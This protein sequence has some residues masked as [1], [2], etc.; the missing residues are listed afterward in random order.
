[1]LRFWVNLVGATSSM[2]L[3]KLNNCRFVKSRIKKSPKQ[4]TQRS[5]ISISFTASA[6]TS[7][8][9]R[10]KRA[11]QF[12]HTIALLELLV[13]LSVDVGLT[14][15]NIIP[16]ALCSLKS[17]TICSWINYFAWPS[18]RIITSYLSL[19]VPL[20]PVLSACL[21]HCTCQSF[22]LDKSLLEYPPW[23]C[24]HLAFSQTQYAPVCQTTYSKCVSF[25]SLSILQG[26]LIMVDAVFLKLC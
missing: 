17:S 9:I 24:Q 21:S 4:T 3:E 14:C 19:C 10:V 8:H 1:M 23:A 22:Q 18:S 2:W 13:S 11:V 12:R 15:L 25:G 16:R 6:A 7:T 5:L 20:S 26:G